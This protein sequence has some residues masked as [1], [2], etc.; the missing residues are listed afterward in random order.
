MTNAYFGRECMLIKLNVG[1]RVVRVKAVALGCTYLCYQ[2]VPSD[3][4]QI[5]SELG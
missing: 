2:S 4:W 3:P 5:G 1:H